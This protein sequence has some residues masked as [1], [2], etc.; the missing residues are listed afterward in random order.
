[1]CLI[2]IHKVFSLLLCFASWL[3]VVIACNKEV[4][5]SSKPRNTQMRFAKC[6]VLVRFRPN[7]CIDE[8][9]TT[10]VLKHDSQ[11]LYNAQG[12]YID[13]TFFFK[14]TGLFQTAVFVMR[15]WQFEKFCFGCFDPCSSRQAPQDRWLSYLKQTLTFPRQLVLLETRYTHWES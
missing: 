7:I 11:C 15:N 5:F 10:Q 13:L 4:F 8:I 12:K 6:L 9:P 14:D 3:C 2:S 1:M